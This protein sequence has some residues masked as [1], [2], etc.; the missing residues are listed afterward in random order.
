M[1]LAVI[2]VTV[3]G[4]RLAAKIQQILPCSIYIK[5][6]RGDNLVEATV[7][8]S[9]SKL[10]PSIFC[11]YDGIVFITA[12]GIAVR[13]IA[14]YI[15][16]KTQDPAV[17][18]LDEQG[19]NAISLLSGHLGGA[20]VLTKKIAMITGAIPI[21]T[22]AT[23]VSGKL[24]ADQ[25][26]TELGLRVVNIEKVKEINGATVAGKQINYYV[27]DSLPEHDTVMRS[28]KA[29]SV[30][31]SKL[32]LNST[33]IIANPAVVITDQDNLVSELSAKVLVL[34]PGKLVAGIGCRRGTKA[35]EI[36]TALS[37]ACQIINKPV[38]S[39]KV[40]ASTTVKQDEDGLLNVAAD[41]AIPIYFYENEIL[42]KT[43]DQYNLEISEFVKK[44]IGVGNIC[45]SAAIMSSQSK[46]LVLRKHKFPKV[47]VA[48]AWEK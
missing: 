11:G 24:A 9:L 43:I 25:L 3:N 27:D 28:L 17:V 34:R 32:A 4:V 7:F 37:E 19:I 48:L 39:I 30:N 21:I 33:D 41:L 15:V 16:H 8:D 23:D 1:K 45:E 13:L 40:L 29:R 36:M 35:T 38:Q 2:A 26:S 5:R 14:P 6:G 18:V 44:Q 20:N 47:T 46:K 10:M 22:T 31:A 42:Q 12:T